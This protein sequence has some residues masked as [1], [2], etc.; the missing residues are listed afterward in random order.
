MLDKQRVRR[1]DER[2]FKVKAKPSLVGQRTIRAKLKIHHE[3]FLKWGHLT[4]HLHWPGLQVQFS[5]GETPNA[6]RACQETKNK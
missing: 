4:L 2:T 3:F 5:C 1:L 6:S